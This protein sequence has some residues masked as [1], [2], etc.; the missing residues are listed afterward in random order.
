MNNQ[1]TGDVIEKYAKFGI[2]IEILADCYKLS[3]STNACYRG[4]VYYKGTNWTSEDMGSRKHWIQSLNDCID[5]ADE[6]IKTRIR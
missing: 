3:D 2:H 1:S 5:F 4:Y 6:L